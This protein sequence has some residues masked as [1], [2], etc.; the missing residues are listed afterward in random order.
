MSRNFPIKTN[1]TSHVPMLVQT[2][3]EH[4][5]YV[6]TLPEHEIRAKL[7]YPA[8]HVRPP[9]SNLDRDIDTI[10]LTILPTGHIGSQ[11]SIVFSLPPLCTIVKYIVGNSTVPATDL[12]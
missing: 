12:Y 5:Y 3:K 1:V 10:M 4:T 11:M 8:A 7:D 2:L 9:P 6:H